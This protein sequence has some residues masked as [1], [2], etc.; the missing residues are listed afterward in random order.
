MTDTR[1]GGQSAPTFSPTTTI[2]NETLSE[3]SAPSLENRQPLTDSQEPTKTAIAQKTDGTE[4][5]G[6]HDRSGQLIRHNLNQA[7]PTGRPT[8]VTTPTGPSPQEV[9]DLQE[10]LNKWRKENGQSRIKED[11]KDSDETRNALLEFQKHYGIKENGVAGPETRKMLSTQVDIIALKNDPQTAADMRRLLASESFKKMPTD[12]QSDVVSRI[13][14]YA[15]AGELDNIGNL[16]NVIDQSDFVGLPLSTKKLMLDTMAARPDDFLLAGSLVRMTN[17]GFGFPRLDE[18]S[19]N[20]VVRRI[21]SYGGDHSKIHSLITIANQTIIPLN[22]PVN[23][24]PWKN[25]MLTKLMSFPPDTD[26]VE[27]MDEIDRNARL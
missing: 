22:Q 9:R 4:K 3:V 15:S 1:I 26:Q 24:L 10:S 21:Q 14:Q 25:E 23:K 27:N 11:G 19:Q 20:W 5:K 13:K 2:A 17:S 7:L 18:T 6:Q 8:R 12:M 16:L